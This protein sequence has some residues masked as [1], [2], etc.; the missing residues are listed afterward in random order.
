MDLRIN[1]YSGKKMYVTN[2]K[3]TVTESRRM[4]KDTS[5]EEGISMIQDNECYI[6]EGDNTISIRGKDIEFIELTSQK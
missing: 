4:N 3:Q 2:Y 6:F 1:T 5:I